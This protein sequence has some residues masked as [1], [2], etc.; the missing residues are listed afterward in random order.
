[1]SSFLRVF[2]NPKPSSVP[3]K[4]KRVVFVGK[5]S[6]VRR[7]TSELVYS[8]KSYVSIAD[9]ETQQAFLGIFEDRSYHARWTS[10]AC[11]YHL[12]PCRVRF[13]GSNSVRRK[14]PRVGI[15]MKDEDKNVDWAP[16]RAD[17]W[18]DPVVETAVDIMSD[19]NF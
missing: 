7:K 8:I 13:G 2:M 11:S 3:P 16:E 18:M 10:C 6:L 12:W 4:F 1:M 15:K 17:S 19:H 9:R 5:G 14:I